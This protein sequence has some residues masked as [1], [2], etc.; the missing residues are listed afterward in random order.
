MDDAMEKVAHMALT[1]L[2]SQNMPATTGMPISLY[3]IQD[4]SDPE[5]KAPMDEASNVILEHHH[6]SWAYMAR[7]A[8]H[9]Y[10]LQHNTQRI[11]ARQWCCLG[12]YAKEVKSLNQE[13]NRMAHEHSVVCQ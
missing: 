4:R 8:Q 5:W 12:S 10:Q 2:C 7:Y 9:L 13:I 6:S 11:I 3:S 1:T